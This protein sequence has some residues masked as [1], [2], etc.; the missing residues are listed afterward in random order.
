MTFE[1]ILDQA[2]AMLQRRGRVTYQTLKLQF[3]LDEEHLEALKDALLFAHPQVVDEGGRGVVW[4]SDADAILPPT[5]ASSPPVDQPVRPAPHADQSA[6]PPLVP[7]MP[8]AERRQLTVLFC[9]LVDSTGAGQPARPGRVARG[10]A[11]LSRDLCQ[12]D[13]PL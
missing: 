1:E 8:D 7:P 3:Q 11:G 9:D 13:R 2:M 12:G 6:A 4:I 5:P 10:G